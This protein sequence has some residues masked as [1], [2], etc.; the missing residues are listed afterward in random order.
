MSGMNADTGRRLSGKEHIEQ[1]ITDIL[2]T[3]IGSRIQRREY[4]SMLPELIDQPISDALVLQMMAAS[5]IAITQW[6]P[7]IKITS[8][9]FDIKNTTGKAQLQL[10]A[11]R[12]D[13]GMTDNLSIDLTRGS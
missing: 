13:T 2:L 3:P 6:E 4:G 9:V 5:V 7:R 12:V 8:V 11:V 10:D 1:S